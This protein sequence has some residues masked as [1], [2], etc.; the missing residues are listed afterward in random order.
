VTPR[1]TDS[2]SSIVLC[3]VACRVVICQVHLGVVL[4]SSTG[5][6]TCPSEH[7]NSNKNATYLALLWLLQSAF[8]RKCSSHH[9]TLKIPAQSQSPPSTMPSHSTPG[10]RSD[11]TIYERL[12][13]PRRNIAPKPR[14]YALPRFVPPRYLHP[15]PDLGFDSP[16]YTTQTP[17]PRQDMR[18]RHGHHPTPR[19][20]LRELEDIQVLDR[21]RHY[22]SSSTTTNTNPPRNQPSSETPYPTTLFQTTSLFVRIQARHPRL[23]HYFTK[24]R[25]DPQ[26]LT[27]FLRRSH[28]TSLLLPAFWVLVHDG[29]HGVVRGFSVLFGVGD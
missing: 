14:W 6:P 29:C 1:K 12:N 3:N 24:Q 8:P 19:P 15:C 25:P 11:L 28:C 16:Q 9:C 21:G 18:I 10:L 22:R 4:G 26:G 27:I 20:H 5:T 2:F 13:R 17:H 7:P 23:H